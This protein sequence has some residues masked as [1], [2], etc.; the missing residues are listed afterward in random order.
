MTLTNKATGYDRPYYAR[1][2]F[3]PV[4]LCYKQ[5]QTVQDMKETSET[6]IAYSKLLHSNIIPTGIQDV[7]QV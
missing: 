3:R 7:C 5:I 6:P 1:D 4:A 2:Y